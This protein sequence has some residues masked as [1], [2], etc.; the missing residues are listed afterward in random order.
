MAEQSEALEELYLFGE[1]KMEK[2]INQLDRKS[3]V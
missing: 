1:E 2:A 3:V